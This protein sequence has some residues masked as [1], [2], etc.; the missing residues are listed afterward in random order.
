MT[1]PNSRP[2]PVPAASVAGVTDDR[3]EVTQRRTTT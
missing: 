3:R 1:R 2:T